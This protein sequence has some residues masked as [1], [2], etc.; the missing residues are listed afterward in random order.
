LANFDWNVL[1]RILPSSSGVR[2][3]VLNRSLKDRDNSGESLD[4]RDLI[5]GKSPEETTAIVRDLVVHEVSQILCIGADRIE[6]GRSLHDLGMDSLM[7]VELALGLEQ[8]F[9]IQLPVMMLN[10]SP[11]AD[12]VSKIIIEKLT[13]NT[14]DAETD[15]STA[16]VEA[17]IRQHGESIS[18]EYVAELARTIDATA[19][20]ETKV[21]A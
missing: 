7:A 18:S 12:K 2:F 4:I 9:G 1:S 17:I 8:R 11:T 16:V 6:P 15:R 13:G 3:Q 10:D 5:A 19:H 20:Q 21:T 14:S